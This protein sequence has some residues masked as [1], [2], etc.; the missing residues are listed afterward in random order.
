MQFALDPEGRV[1]AFVD[2]LVARDLES[3]R[4]LVDQLRAAGTSIETLYSG[5]TD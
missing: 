3:V 5:A 4:S 1:A 2:A